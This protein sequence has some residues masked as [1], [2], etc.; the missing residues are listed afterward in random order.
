MNWFCYFHRFSIQEVYPIQEVFSYS[1]LSLHPGEVLFSSFNECTIIKKS[2][3]CCDLDAWTALPKL[4][5][6][7]WSFQ[8]SFQKFIPTLPYSFPV[9]VY[10]FFFFNFIEQCSLI[11]LK[12]RSTGLLIEDIRKNL[13]IYDYY[14]LSIQFWSTPSSELQ[15]MSKVGL[16]TPLSQKTMFWIFPKKTWRRDQQKVLGKL[17]VQTNPL[18]LAYLGYFWENSIWLVNY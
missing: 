17:R 15:W 8:T 12:L 16:W 3:S 1:G 13:R 5:S 6:L 2:P 9:Y 11:S 14:L 10:F 18:N 4:V 7:I